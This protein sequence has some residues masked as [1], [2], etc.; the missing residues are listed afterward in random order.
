M[1]P[2]HYKDRREEGKTL[3]RQCQ[4]VQLHLLYVFDRICKENELT[5]CLSGGTLLGA[6]RHDGFI[7]WD[8]DLDVA[9]PMSDF[10]RFLSIAPRCLP[11]D[12]ILQKP[13]DEPRSGYRFAKLRDVDS[14]FFEPHSRVPTSA[15]NG[16][17]LDIF[18]YEDCPAIPESFR[19]KIRWLTSSFYEHQLKNLYKMTECPI[20]FGWWFY[21]KALFCAFSHSCLRGFWRLLQL[22][23][24]G[25]NICYL[26]DF[27][28]V[29]LNMPKE[30]LKNM[31][32]HRFEDGEFP[33]PH[34]ADVAL[35]QRY[36]DWRT[37][38]P[39]DQRT[40][41]VTFMDPFHCV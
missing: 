25:R 9:M 40:G 41:H 10:R 20:L 16:I 30:W 8:D 36:G 33:I 4:L 38:L 12:V 14:F 24:P 32:T 21:A 2:L 27:W 15:P 3:L 23:L 35:E 11:K 37:P 6:L 17:Y 19:R 29:K 34:H 1:I 22:I 26:L 39:P 31:P 13:G 18:P 5:Y 7:P 28:E